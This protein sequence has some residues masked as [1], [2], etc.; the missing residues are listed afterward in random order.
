MTGNLSSFTDFEIHQQHH[1]P[2]PE[3]HFSVLHLNTGKKE[4]NRS[5]AGKYVVLDNTTANAVLKA[6]KEKMS[7]GN[8]CPNITK[9]SCEQKANPTTLG[10]DLDSINC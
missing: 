5:A 9:I 8:T 2:S 3:M 1:L 7:G 10:Y 4:P 6:S